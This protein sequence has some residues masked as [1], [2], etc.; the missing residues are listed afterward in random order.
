MVAPA[1]IAGLD[2]GAKIYGQ[3]MTNIANRDMAREQMRFQERM[4]STAYQRSKL[5][6][7]KA[8]LNPMLAFQ[9][10]AA[11][12][13]GGSMAVQSNILSGGLSSAMDIKR[14]HA[15]IENLKTQNEKLISDTELNRA[16]ARQTLATAKSVEAAQP[17]KETERE[18]DQTKYGKGLRYIDRLLDTL[19]PLK[20]FK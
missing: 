13:P 9:Q 15:E 5:D 16:V 10:G 2:T 12:S 4:S 1:V 14:A 18:I 6:M 17:G 11:S 8:G 19:N 3:H 20:V 7:E